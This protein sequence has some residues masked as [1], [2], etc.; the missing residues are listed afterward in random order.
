MRT[1][2]AIRR[3][4]AALLFLGALAAVVLLPTQAY[5]KW[6]LAAA[7]VLA[8]E[9]ALAPRMLDAA[10]RYQNYPRLRRR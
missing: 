10:T 8:L 5:G 2:P 7:L 3:F 1:T 9:W 4:F 6:L